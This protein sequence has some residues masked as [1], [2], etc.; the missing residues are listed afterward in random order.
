MVKN[1]TCE[2]CS[3]DLSEGGTCSN[4]GFVSEEK[5]KSEENPSEEEET[6]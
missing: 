6:E 2:E 4:C 5:E 1:T 3:S